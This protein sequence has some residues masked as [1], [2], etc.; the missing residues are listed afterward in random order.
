LN[1]GF[2]T[3]FPGASGNASFPAVYEAFLNGAHKTAS[4]NTNKT[5]NENADAIQPDEQ[6]Q[7]K[8]KT[9]SGA[10]AHLF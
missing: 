4:E 7:K 10:F 3:N 2:K 1:G 9:K 6:T 5:A 8:Q